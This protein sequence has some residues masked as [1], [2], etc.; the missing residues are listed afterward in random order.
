DV[1]DGSDVHFDVEEAGGRQ[2]VELFLEDFG[3]GVGLVDV[4]VVPLAVGQLGQVLDEAGVPFGADAHEA[5]VDLVGGGFRVQLPAASLAGGFTVG[6]HHDLG[7][8]AA[9]RLLLDLVHA[10]LDALVH[11]RAA[12]INVVHIDLVDCLVDLGF[13]G[14]RRGGEEHQGVVGKA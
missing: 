4:D 10:Q 12:R 9:L 3:G 1:L 6:Q 13:V 8:A 7:E 14:D 5:E 11:R 2:A